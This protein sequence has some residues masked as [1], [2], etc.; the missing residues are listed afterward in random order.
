MF[1]L[2]QDEG[3][4]AGQLAAGLYGCKS[5]NKMLGLAPIALTMAGS[6]ILTCPKA[7]LNM[8]AE[9]C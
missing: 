3:K 7:C 1:Y 8:P 2:K 5:T 9:I 6:C 4:I